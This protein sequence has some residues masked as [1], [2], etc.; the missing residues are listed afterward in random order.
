MALE[1]ARAAKREY[2][3]ILMKNKNVVACGVG[4]KRVGGQ[5]TR[6]PSVVVSVIKKLPPEALAVDEIIPRVVGT[7]PTDII[8]TGVIRALQSPTDRW[9]P[10]PGGVSIGHFNI[11]AGT[12]GCLVTRGGELFIL[13]NNH[14][15]ANSNAANAGDSI[16]QPG[17]YDGG[18]EADRIA[19]LEAFVP[20]QFETS[21]PTCLVVSDLVFVLNVLARLAGSRHR[22]LGYRAAAEANLV[23]AAIARPLSVDL[24]ER[25]ILNIGVPRGSREADLG[26]AI[27]KSGRTTGFTT[28]EIQ[29]I[30]AS[31]RVSYGNSGTALFQDQ[32]VAG[33]MSQGGDSG[34][35]VLDA[36]GYVIGLLF[37]G[38]DT[39][40]IINR[41]S[42]VTAALNVS[43][44]S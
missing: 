22:I 10:A 34:S 17:K 38:S 28:G 43:I 25:R 30:D 35:A 21:P 11:T 16:L 42:N 13:S 27:R 6:E 19:T 44:A 3:D 14:V 36:D 41:I 4:Y 24:V 29:Q 32:F 5:V 2:V 8:E 12:L 18:T 1:K 31:V 23:D 40:T 9:R 15:L 37:A 39:T 7:M 20:I 26:T 33:A